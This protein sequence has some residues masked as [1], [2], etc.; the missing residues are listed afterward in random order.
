LRKQSGII[1]L[2][3][4]EAPA[5]LKGGGATGGRHL[6]QITPLSALS[7]LPATFNADTFTRTLVTLIGEAGKR[8]A[9]EAAAAFADDSSAPAVVAL[10]GPAQSALTD[11][12]AAGT[13]LGSWAAL[14]PS[15]GN[16]LET[17]LDNTNGGGGAV[18][19]ALNVAASLRSAATAPE[20]R[21]AL[22]RQAAQLLLSLAGADGEPGVGA[23]PTSIL[24]QALRAL[25]SADQA[26]AP[27]DMRAIITS[28]LAEAAKDSALVL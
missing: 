24:Q 20:E 19:A 3:E 16:L 28:R 18:A 8:F 12:A 5:A 13:S 27:Q 14:L 10:S 21:G 17:V 2:M 25:S 9:R 11:I 4:K 23:P 15:A 22:L 1:A 7:S 26:P 6:L